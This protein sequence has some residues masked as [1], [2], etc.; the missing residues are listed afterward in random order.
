MLLV[1]GTSLPVAHLAIR[2]GLRPRGKSECR[3]G[4]F[5]TSPDVVYLTNAYGLFYAINA[6]DDSDQEV[7][8]IEIDTD[9]IEKMMVAD[10]DTLEQT[11]RMNRKNPLYP[12]D[13]D[14]AW[15]TAKRTQWFAKNLIIGKTLGYDH[16]WSLKKMGN[17]AHFGSIPK[18]AITRI[19]SIQNV[20]HMWW[21]QFFDPTITMANFIFLGEQYRTSQLV[22]MGRMEEAIE[23]SGPA[24]RDY[25]WWLENLIHPNRKVIY[26][27]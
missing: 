3:W 4:G 20:N 2:Q 13:F 21:L 8:L 17:C 9:V 19:V 14:P 11:Y 7:C 10:E 22:L 15:N 23:F 18:D 5:P 12:L 26:E 1:H 16:K 25:V 27:R 6:A 24:N